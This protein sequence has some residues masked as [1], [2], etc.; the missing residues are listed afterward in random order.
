MLTEFEKDQMY[1]S[2]HEHCKLESWQ[3][4]VLPYWIHSFCVTGQSWIQIFIHAV[5][6][7]NWHFSCGLLHF[8]YVRPPTCRTVT[9]QVGGDVQLEAPQIMYPEELACLSFLANNK[10]RFHVA[11]VS[12]TNLKS[13]QGHLLLLAPWADA[14]GFIHTCCWASQDVEIAMVSWKTELVYF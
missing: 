1:L 9:S 13:P 11:A 2:S 3:I 12:S 8:L 4:A 6:T 7:E 14:S 5:R 10:W